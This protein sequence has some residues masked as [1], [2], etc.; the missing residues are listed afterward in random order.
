MHAQLLSIIMPS[1][2]QASFIEGSVRSVLDQDWPNLEVV[3]A[4]GASTDDT[5]AI[6]QR[7]AA[8]DSRLR[9]F[10]ESDTG[11][12]SALNKAL[13]QVRGTVVGWLNSDDLYTPGACRRSM[14]AFES[15]PDWL[16]VYGHGE[17]VDAAGHSLN[18]YPTLPPITPIEQFLQGCFICQPTMFFR[19]IVPL[20][21]GTLDESLGCAFD[22]DYWLRAF[23]SFPGRIGFV[24]ALQAQSRLHE[25]CITTRARRQVALEGLQV[26][27]R[28]LGQAPGVWI[29]TFAE[30]LIA[31][32][33]A[34]PDDGDLRSAV[35]HLLD[36]SRALLAPEEVQ[37]LQ[38]RFAADTRL[39]ALD[40]E[41]PIDPGKLIANHD[42]SAHVQ[43]ADAYFAGREE[44]WHLYQK[45]F[46]HPQDCAPQLSNLGDLFGGL[47]LKAG[48]RV[49]DFAAGSCWLTRY[50]LQLGCDVVA[51][52][53]SVRAL[54]IGKE[55][56]RR[57]PPIAPSYL[58]PQF[59][60]FDGYR[61]D[62]PDACLDRIV[63]NDAFHHLPNTAAV[64]A[65]FA[66]L[67][68]PDG[69]VGMSEPGRYHSQTAASQAE[70]REFYVI[71]NDVVLEDL[72]QEAQHAGFADIAICPVL[73]SQSMNIDDYLGCIQ[74]RIPPQVAIEL[75]QGT[76]NQSIFFLFKQARQGHA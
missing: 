75:M 26:L 13:A 16:L 6:L 45:P 35:L 24:D 46:Y 12:A 67:L 30:E 32:R 65:E 11:P 57:F 23:K 52:D 20:L 48:M 51:C 40:P 44:Q 54:G 63:V 36:E 49:L 14:E 71:E 66:R 38:A 41:A 47:Q 56:L 29:E 21:L 2:N 39:A 43:L 68:K 25:H 28:H 27:H 17:H 4:D 74:Q 69:I 64:L 37:R 70:M 42:I 5:V 55:L 58:P 60:P 31:G 7:L 34:P 3:V 15:Q 76:V 9:W 19:R 53:A 61:I 22:F 10:S 72:W 73:R 50:L 1:Y 8:A 33:A 62:L 59:L 18:R